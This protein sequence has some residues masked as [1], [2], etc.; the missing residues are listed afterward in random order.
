MSLRAV[1]SG[2][3]GVLVTTQRFYERN[4][5]PWRRELSSLELVLH[6]DCHELRFQPADM[7]F[8]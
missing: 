8:F 1:A 2:K 6:T 5:A 3:A 7:I 4:V